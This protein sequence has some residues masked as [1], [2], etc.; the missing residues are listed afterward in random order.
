MQPPSQTAAAGLA[1]PPLTPLTTEHV[2]S[3]AFYLLSEYPGRIGG[4]TVWVQ[5]QGDRS[6]DDV[7]PVVIGS[8]DWAVRLGGRW[9]RA[10]TP[11]AVEAGR[12]N[13]P[14]PTASG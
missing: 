8:H 12:G 11:I 7:S 10:G 9:R 13:A 14:W 5:R 4:D 3:R 2:L 1:I 6:N